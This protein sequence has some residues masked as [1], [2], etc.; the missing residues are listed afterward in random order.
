[1]YRNLHSQ[2]APLGREQVPAR[3]LTPWSLFSRGRRETCHISCGDCAWQCSV[4]SR[5]WGAMDPLS[6]R[7]G[8]IASKVSSV[9]LSPSGCTQGPLFTLCPREPLV[10]VPD[11]PTPSL[12]KPLIVK[13]RG[14][15][16]V[17]KVGGGGTRL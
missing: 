2:E 9:F 14:K 3:H 8:S 4:W 1:M 11:L 7:D 6:P 16:M 17:P 15:E 5:V 13:Q 12:E 10:S